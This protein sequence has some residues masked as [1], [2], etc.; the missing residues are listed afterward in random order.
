MILGNPP[1]DLGRGNRDGSL[2]RRLEDSDAL[3]R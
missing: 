1:N 3:R 2:L